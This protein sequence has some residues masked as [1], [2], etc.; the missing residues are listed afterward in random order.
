MLGGG[1]GGEDKDI[2][3]QLPIGDAQQQ[4]E[5]TNLIPVSSK[6]RVYTADQ[7]SNTVSV[8]DPGSNRLLGV[9][10]LGDV[11]PCTLNPP[12]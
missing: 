7:T 1:G 9:I 6:D 2:Q 11:V 4:Q 12:V 10:R 8:I 3:Q 5:S